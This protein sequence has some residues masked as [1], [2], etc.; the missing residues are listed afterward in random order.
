MKT[1]GL[2]G[3]MSW[4]STVEYYR[5]INRE[6]GN[7]LGGVHSGDILMRSFDFQNIYTP[8][9][10]GRWDDLAAYVADAAKGLEREGADCVLICTN[11]V[12]NVAPQVEAA[13]HVPLIHIGDGAGT[14]AKRLGAS[15]IGLL[16]T[17]FTMELDFYASRLKTDYAVDTVIPNTEDRDTVNRIIWNELIKGD[18]RD[19]SRAA[20]AQVIQ[21]LAAQG[22]EAVVLGCTEIPLLIGADDSPLPLID[23]TAEHALAAVEFALGE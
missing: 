6:V 1:I 12:H 4:E 2:L 13:L 21:R 9:H 23:T 14:A 5:L 22:A 10:E 7:R 17:S 15:K 11:T 8:I 19:E 20:Y 18:I 3:G 16:G